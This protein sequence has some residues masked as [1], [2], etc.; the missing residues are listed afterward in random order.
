MTFNDFFNNSISDELQVNLL[1]IQDITLLLVISTFIGIYIF[2]IYTLVC[3]K[4]FYSKSFATS[5]IAITIITALIILTIKQSI[6]ISLGMVGALSIVRFRTPIKEP[7]DLVFI[8]WSIAMGIIC[9]A[10]IYEVAIY[11]SIVITIILLLMNHLP[12]IHNSLLMVINADKNFNEEDSIN[13]LKKY[14][15]EYLIKSRNINK[16]NVDLIIEI[17]T[18]K[19]NETNIIKEISALDSVLNVSLMTHEGEMA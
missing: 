16:G 7:V 6:V 18:E 12:S 14:A 4:T 15:K 2:F 13:I 10:N 11:G 8:Y 3:K 5:L 19:Q 1:T 17:K 9:G